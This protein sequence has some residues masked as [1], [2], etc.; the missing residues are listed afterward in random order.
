MSE[1][2]APRTSPYRR[3]AAWGLVLVLLGAAVFAHRFDA[4][5]VCPVADCW[6]FV[7]LK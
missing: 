4:L 1:R 2:N 3:Q 7:I 5:P 6:P